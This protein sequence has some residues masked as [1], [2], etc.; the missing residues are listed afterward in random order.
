MD[1]GNTLG[2]G[3]KGTTGNG[4]GRVL[5]TMAPNGSEFSHRV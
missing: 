4:K 5:Y 1:R 2:V 3:G